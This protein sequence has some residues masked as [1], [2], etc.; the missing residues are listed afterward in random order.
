MYRVAPLRLDVVDATTLEVDEVPIPLVIVPPSPV[1]LVTRL[2][3]LIEALEALVSLI[4]DVGGTATVDEKIEV[5]RVIG[6]C[7]VAEGVVGACAVVEGESGACTVI[8]DVVGE[9]PAGADVD[10]DSLARFFC[11]AAKVVECVYD[12]VRG[13][14]ALVKRAGAPE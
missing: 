14:F 2:E 3:T 13:P 11:R 4:T 9:V 10:V 7:V 12:V 1:A 8:E 5:E 6:G